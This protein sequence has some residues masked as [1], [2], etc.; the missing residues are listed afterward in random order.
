MEKT[1]IIET[2]YGKI[3]GYIEQ[4][5]KIF[6]GIPYT[7]PPVGDLRFK[8]PIPPEP[9]RRVRNA[10]EFGPICP[11]PSDQTEKSKMK[12]PL[13]QDEANCL[14]LNIWTP[15]LDNEKRPVM[16]W[17]HGGGFEGGSSAEESY[18]GL[19]L[20]LRGDVVVVT[21][22]YRLGTLGYFYIPGK[23]ANVGQLDQIAALK[24][25]QD[26]IQ[27]F[28]GDPNNV[29]VFG[30]S[31]GGT[32][33]ITLLAMPDAKGL[34]HRAISQSAYSFNLTDHKEGSDTFS[35]MLKINPGDINSLQKVPIDEI[36][37]THNLFIGENKKKG[38]DNPF[39]PVVDGKTLL[40]K[41]VIALQNGIAKEI[42]LLIGNNRDEMKYLEEKLA[43]Y[44]KDIASEELLKRI[45]F[46]LQDEQLAK[47]LINTYI[48]ERE[49]ILPNEPMDILGTFQ[50]D[51]YFRILSIR[52]AEAKSRHH[53]NTYMYLFTWSSPWM[54]GKLGACHALEIPLVFGTL[55]KPGMDIFCGKG[56]DVEAL[57]EKM[58]DAWIAFAHS[59]DPNHKNIPEWPSYDSVN[60]STMIIDKEFKIVNDPFGKEREAWDKFNFR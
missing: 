30:E 44:V 60:R 52:V 10:T 39:S 33:V 55:D 12:T 7:S 27:L 42:P 46:Y 48:K 32:A 54:D 36:K 3:Q 11:Q 43:G 21:I 56:K 22:N 49:D 20:S 9:W 59:G 25:I 26:N 29:T 24:W 18:S 57:S 5:I 13:E 40:E 35:S 50:T 41:P 45:K 37:K 8:P 4:G 58:M 34:F 23:T 6:K 31:A 19:A 28:G 1:K 47:N 16:F 53:K 38:R 15:E 51:F 14:T 17:I 2:K